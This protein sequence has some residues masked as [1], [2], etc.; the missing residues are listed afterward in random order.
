MI[1]HTMRSTSSFRNCLNHPILGGHF[2]EPTPPAVKS[3]VTQEMN[4][5]GEDDLWYRVLSRVSFTKYVRALGLQITVTTTQAM[6]FLLSQVWVLA[7]APLSTLLL[8]SDLS[9]SVRPRGPPTGKQPPFHLKTRLSSAPCAPPALGAAP[10]A[11]C[12]LDGC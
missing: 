5:L 4:S 12:A 7:L 10:G 2:L 3:S 8:H 6:C 11:L 1:L 9:S